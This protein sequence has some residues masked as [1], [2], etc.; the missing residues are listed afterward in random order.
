[1][2][3]VSKKITN[4]DVFN[5]NIVAYIHKKKEDALLWINMKS[6]NSNVILLHTMMKSME[7]SLESYFAQN[8]D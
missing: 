7:K 1:M 4:E 6:I 3:S 2:D 5:V 8:R